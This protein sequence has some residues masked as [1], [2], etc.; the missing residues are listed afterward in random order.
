MYVGGRDVL[1][2]EGP[3]AAADLLEHHHGVVADALTLHGD[4][5]FGDAVDHFRL[6]LWRKHILDHL[7]IDVRHDVFRLDRVACLSRSIRSR[8]SCGEAFDGERADGEWS[9]SL[10]GPVRGAVTRPVTPYPETVG[11]SSNR[12]KEWVRRCSRI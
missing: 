10:V 1:T 11:P 2:T 8:R 3:V 5:C 12:P 9:C 6:L 7:D 4:N